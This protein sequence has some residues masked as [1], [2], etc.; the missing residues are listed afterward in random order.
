MKETFEIETEI[1]FND[2][3]HKIVERV[4]IG[5]IVLIGAIIHDDKNSIFF[6]NIVSTNGGGSN[7]QITIADADINIVKEKRDLVFKTFFKYRKQIKKDYLKAVA[8]RCM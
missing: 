7:A 6:F 3:K 2:K 4:I 1:N 5:H 8:Q